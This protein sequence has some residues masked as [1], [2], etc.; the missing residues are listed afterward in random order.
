[1]NSV[2]SEVLITYFL[3]KLPVRYWTAK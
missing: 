1:M 2:T 3:G